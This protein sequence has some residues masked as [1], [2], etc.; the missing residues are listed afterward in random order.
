MSNIRIPDFQ[1]SNHVDGENFGQQQEKECEMSHQVRRMKIGR[2]K[3]QLSNSAQGTPL[4]HPK[5]MSNSNTNSE[6][7]VAATNNPD[8]INCQPFSAARELN[9]CT[10]GNS[11][12][13]RPIA[14]SGDKP[15]PQDVLV[16]N[17]DG[18][19]WTTASSKLYLSPTSLPL[20]IPACKGQSLVSWGKKV[21]LVGGTGKLILQL[22]EFQCGHLTQKQL[23]TYAALREGKTLLTFGG[24]TKSRTLN[25]LYSL[26]FDT[27][28][29]SK[30]KKRAFYP[31]PR[32]GCCGVLFG[33]KW[34]I[35]GGGSHKKWHAETLV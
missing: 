11:E 17:F 15:A 18:F 22:T 4:R 3:V 16:L 9:S 6:S 21:L 23:V 19:S 7:G 20:K 27:I 26:D 8:E 25:D 2:L 14:I 31:S 24:A 12:N 34:Y 5:R 30:M 35:A 10:S 1:C 29:W 32:A 28:I 13:W 33:T